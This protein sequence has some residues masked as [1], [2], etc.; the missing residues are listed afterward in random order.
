MA[1][2]H[3]AKPLG[4][5]GISEKGT[6]VFQN[7]APNAFSSEV[8]HLNKDYPNGYMIFTNVDASSGVL[9]FASRG[10][11]YTEKS[12]RLEVQNTTNNTGTAIA[13]WIAVAK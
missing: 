5:G 12:F 6:H 4:G 1:L 11:Y 10:I 8:I 7:V 13:S 3:K 2:V 9:V